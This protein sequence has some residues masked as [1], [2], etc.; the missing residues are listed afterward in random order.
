[1]RQNM[2]VGGIKDYVGELITAG[3]G[4]LA[5]LT[6]YSQGKKQAKTT[7]LDNVEKA[8]KIWEDTSTR[9]NTNL[10]QVESDMKVLKQNHEECEKSKAEL[11]DKVCQLD[12]RVCELTEALHNV[13]GTPKEKRK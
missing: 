13:I 6:A 12:D 4:V 3:G 2:D 5:A 11:S 10:V 7:H 1:M 8:I 9:L